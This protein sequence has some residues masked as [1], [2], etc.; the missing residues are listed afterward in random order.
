MLLYGI[1]SLVFFVAAG[2]Y[3]AVRAI[4]LDFSFDWV[5]IRVDEENRSAFVLEWR[6]KVRMM[7]FLTAA[8]GCFFLVPFGDELWAQWMGGAAGGR[9]P[10]LLLAAI[11]L[12]VL[13][14][15]FWM[16]IGRAYPSVVEVKSFPVRFGEWLTTPIYWLTEPFLTQDDSRAP[17]REEGEVE[18]KIPDEE[19]GV[20][21]QMIKNAIEFKEVRL[22]D[23]M[24]PRTEISGIDIDASV[25]EL[26]EAFVNSGHSK[27]VVYRGSVDNIQGYCHMLSMFKK[28]KEIQQIVS[29]ILTV[30]EAMPASDLMI[31]F[32]E[33]RKNLAVV[34]DE[35]GGTAGLVSIEDIIEQIFGEIQDE[36]DFTEDWVERKLDDQRYLLSARHEIDYLNEKYNWD[37]PEG[38][39]DTLGG[40]I[41]SLYEDIP[42]VGEVIDLPPYS[43][44]VDAA[45]DNRLETILVTI[46]SPVT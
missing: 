36:Y 21:E 33:E 34:V 46:H 41:I 1:L 39:Y 28:P 9:I 22:R 6:R 3:G 29:P 7:R 42:E 25:D 17:H 2:Y 13:G 12:W 45:Q 38:D 10:A 18:E 43:F 35:F 20:D 8:I 11:V 15:S 4:S 14:M 26:R 44:R 37:L 19:K 32:L 16:G 40:L 5:N 23:C 27:I 24:I 31:R 30:P